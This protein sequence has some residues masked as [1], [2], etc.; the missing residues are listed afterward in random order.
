MNFLYMLLIGCAVAITV[1]QGYLFFFAPCAQVKEFWTIV[2][3]P[4]RCI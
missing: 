4:G 3:V 2:K 1:F